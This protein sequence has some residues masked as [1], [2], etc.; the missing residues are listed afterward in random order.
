MCIVDPLHSSLC[1]KSCT[2][3]QLY[4]GWELKAKDYTLTSSQGLYTCDSDDTGVTLIT[5]CTTSCGKA[6]PSRCNGADC[7][8]GVSYCGHQLI[9]MYWNETI[10]K[11]ETLYKCTAATSASGVRTCTKC[12]AYG[13]HSYCHCNPGTNYCGHE[14]LDKFSWPSPDSS[15]SYECSSDGTLAVGKKVCTH[16][17]DYGDTCKRQNCRSGAIYCGH[18]LVAMDWP[19]IFYS[20]QARYKCLED[21][22]S[23]AHGKSIYFPSG[24]EPFLK[25]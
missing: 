17:C 19:A 24:Y 9:E 25:V 13:D 14:L 2:A 12:K 20:A 5:S 15:T 4:C 23:A 3:G 18:E 22:V 21:G 11:K 1:S 6:S 10:T 16:G 7:T 8:I